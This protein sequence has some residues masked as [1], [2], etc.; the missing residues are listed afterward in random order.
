MLIGFLVAAQHCDKSVIY[1]PSYLILLSTLPG[2]IIVIFTFQ[3]STF[4]LRD[5]KG[6][7]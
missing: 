1:V 6:G 2:S 5:L 4:R 7:A 3:V